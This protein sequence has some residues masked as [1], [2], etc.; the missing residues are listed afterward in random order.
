MN[1]KLD[2][3]FDNVIKKS[4][5]QN[6][7]VLLSDH[8]PTTILHREQQI[9][10]V[11]KI[12]SCALR[13]EK[14]SNLFIYGK[15]G[16]GKTL[17]IKYII[18]ELLKK[19]KEL[20]LALNIIYTNCKLKKVSDTEYRIIAELINLLGSKVPA[21]GLPTD[22]VYK[23]FIELVDEKQ[24]LLIIVL[25]EIDEAVK[26]IGDA[27]LYNLTRL[28]SELINSQISLVGISNDLTFLDSLDPRVKSSLSEEE[29][30]F[31][32]YNAL[33]LQDILRERAKRAFKRGAIS[34]GV[35]EK[36]AALAA[37]EHG[38]ARRAI[39]LLR[40]AGE[41]AER[42]GK[43]KLTLDLIDK[44][45]EKIERDKI[46]DLVETQPRHHQLI[47]FAIIEMAEKKEK[48]KIYTG[49]IYNKYVELCQEQ[50]LEPLT[51]RR[52]SDIVAELDMLGI[53]NAQVI[54]KGRYG[55]T[56]E[57]K[58]NLPQSLILKIKSIINQA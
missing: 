26:K 20:N 55:R 54:S 5:F 13:L 3:I 45:I 50:R 49:D 2:K 35:I 36:I 48:E 19:T 9:K 47:L 42:E 17:V 23:K 52:V 8:T 34:K 14:P 18:N 16:T 6:K 41:L 28:N 33:Q 39:D 46:I 25:D 27:F 43:L 40:V 11:A 51:Q 24:Q 58:I 31:P 38:D 57:I 56:R 1:F 4:I 12:L 37:K 15:T 29:L 22:Q 7:S 21:T 10:Q 32:P 30:V 44:A 53:I